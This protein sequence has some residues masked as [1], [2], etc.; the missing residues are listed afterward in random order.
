MT[1]KQAISA[2]KKA[3]KT[4]SGLDEA[5]DL[6]YQT[7]N[8]AQFTDILNTLLINPNH[9]RHQFV[10]K[11]IQTNK[12]P[13]SVPYIQ[14]VLEKGFDDFA[15]TCSES[16]VV[17]KWFSWALFAIGTKEA[18]DLIRKYAQSDDVGIRE[19]MVYRLSKLG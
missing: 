15:Y 14:Q 9:H 12:S 10:T 18:I 11:C 1:I 19:E 4:N 5:I 16:G 8:D 17:A 6:I 3:I 7:G 2:I 13:S